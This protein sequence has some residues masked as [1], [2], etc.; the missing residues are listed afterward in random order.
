MATFRAV[1][2]FK[3]GKLIK[4]Y[5]SQADAGRAMKVSGVSIRNYCLG[6]YQPSDGSQWRYKY[7]K[8]GDKKQSWWKRFWKRIFG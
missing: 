8:A 4:E 2:Q 7:P 6:V 3:D 1:Q 5:K